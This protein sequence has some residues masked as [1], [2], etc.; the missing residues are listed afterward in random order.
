MRAFRISD[1]DGLAQ[2]AAG[3]AVN[4]SVRGAEAWTGPSARGCRMGR[5]DESSKTDRYL[6]R[7]LRLMLSRPRLCIARN[8]HSSARPSLRPFRAAGTHPRFRTAHA[9]SIESIF[10]DIA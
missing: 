2:A 5:A 4:S 6:A 8:G 9:R 3:I 7:D 10:V 1:F